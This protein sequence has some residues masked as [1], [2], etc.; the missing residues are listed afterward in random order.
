WRARQFPTPQAGPGGTLIYQ[1]GDWGH[2]ATLRN[3]WNHVS[4]HQYQHI[5]WNTR[6][7]KIGSK[8]LRVPTASHS[9][10]EETLQMLKWL[11]NVAL[12]FLWLIALTIVGALFSW[13]LFPRLGWLLWLIF[14]INILV[15]VNYKANEISYITN[16]LFPSYI[17]I[18]LWTGLGYHSVSKVLLRWNPP[19]QNLGRFALRAFA[20]IALATQWFL[21]FPAINHRT[22]TRARD[23]A[24]QRVD[25]VQAL[26]SKTGKTVNVLMV[27]DDT[28]FPFWY[29]QRVRGK[30]PDAKT[31]W[32]P[33]RHY[34]W[35]SGHAMD[36]VNQLH[37]QNP[38]AVA[39]WNP[40]I[41][42]AF[43]L[44]PLN[45]SGT[46]WLAS[47][48]VL[49]EPAKVLLGS[50]DGGQELHLPSDIKTDELFA[51]TLD[52]T[53]DLTGHK[54]IKRDSVNHTIQVGWVEI[55]YK[56]PPPPPPHDAIPNGMRQLDAFTKFNSNEI[57]Q[58]LPIVIPEN[59][60]RTTRL[61]M[62]LP[63]QVPR[64]ITESACDIWFHPTG[65]VWQRISAVPV[66]H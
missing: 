19:K 37:K 56:V 63:L 18:A 61:Q 8:Y 16:L 55:A 12:Q 54:I 47:N 40:Q 42:A 60:K 66:V 38:L 29:E 20:I 13:K 31:P 25:A 7:V 59:L 26:Q 21:V 58:R 46:L 36:F 24:L 17:V 51:A 50:H 6:A 23:T 65:G 30:V 44:V 53:F 43:P 4:A 48:R 32:G 45:Q 62:I 49:P 2:P 10:S 3:W 33:F 22:D 15:Q 5:L 27:T 52:F 41:N 9:L 64:S 1:P 11:G 28:I 35:D 14:G 39:E 34:Y 57:A